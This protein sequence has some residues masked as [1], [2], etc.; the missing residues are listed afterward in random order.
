MRNPFKQVIL[1]VDGDSVGRKAIVELLVPQGHQVLESANGAKALALIRQKRPALVLLDTAMPDMSGL[2]VLAAL[3]EDGSLSRS[4]VVLMSSRDN[5]SGNQAKGLDMG[6]AGYITRPVGRDEL[7]AHIRLHLRQRAL[8]DS[9]RERVKE[10]HL[11]HKAAELIYYSDMPKDR[12]LAQLVSLLPAAMQYPEYAAARITYNDSCAETAG[13]VDGLEGLT[14]RFTVAGMYS[15]QVKVVYC[16]E[17]GNEYFEPDFLDEEKRMLQSLADMLRDYFKHRLAGDNLARSQSLLRIAGKTAKLGGWS[18]EL[19]ERKIT[20]SDE[21]RDILEVPADYTPDLEKAI[22]FYLPSDQPVVSEAVDSCIR[23]GLPFDIELQIN[24]ATGCQKW[25]RLIGGAMH[26]PDNRIIRVQGAFQDISDRKKLERQ[27]LRAQRMESIGTL[28]GGVAHD[29]NNLLTPIVMGV[30]LLHKLDTDSKYKAIIK[31]MRK[32]AEHGRDLVRQV[33]SFARGADGEHVTVTPDHLIREIEAII[34]NTFPKNIQLK[35]VLPAGLWTVSGDP[36]QLH[37]VML[38]LCVNA[39]DA[40]PDG[41]CLTLGAENLSVDSNFA[42]MFEKAKPGDYLVFSITDTGMGMDKKTLDRIFEPFF[43]TK[44][45]GKGTGLGLSTAMGIVRSH[46]GFINVYSEPGRGTLFKVYLPAQTV[47]GSR[48]ASTAR[49]PD[50]P[51][52]NGEYILV[53]DDEASILAMSE[54]T[55]KVYGYQVLCAENGG[56]A[57]QVFNQHAADVRLIVTDMMMPE[58]DGATLIR[59]LRSQNPDIPIIASSGLHSNH[60]GPE[61]GIAH[62]LA[63]P[64]SAEDLLRTVHAT[65]EPS[66]TRAE[67]H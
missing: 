54:Q 44:E 27:F 25:V 65:L 12:L 59:H 63:K 10:L 31:Q 52:G 28:A 35:Q 56:K 26:G 61:S 40:M 46:G 6:A 11:L 67:R 13:Y 55:L 4:S 60:P 50:L 32:S 43:T 15:G 22:G 37:Q 36:T 18:I 49:I 8:N 23:D 62:F 14:V 20:W 16:R 45:S 30:D 24:T 57:L 2:E 42:V 7:L 47:P 39:R 29:F 17:P 41:G 1:V 38:N 48:K 9:L 5:A 58:M 21:I 33:L 53:V 34:T 3:H 19:P 64:Y 51:R 66:H